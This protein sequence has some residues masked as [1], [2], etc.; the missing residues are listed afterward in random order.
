MIAVYYKRLRMQGKVESLPEEGLVMVHW[1]TGGST[2]INVTE[3]E[4]VSD[5]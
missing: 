3:L 5:G 1:D 2:R 4:Q